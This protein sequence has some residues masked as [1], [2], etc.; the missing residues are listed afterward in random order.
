[1]AGDR[2]GLDSIKIEIKV[3][4]EERRERGRERKRGPNLERL[5]RRGGRNIRRWMEFVVHS[6]MLFAIFRRGRTDSDRYMWICR[7]PK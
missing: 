6:A 7:F 5:H 4:R 3:E 1:M 2:Y